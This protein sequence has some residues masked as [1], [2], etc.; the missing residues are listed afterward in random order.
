[1]V[2]C[3]GLDWYGKSRPHWDSIPGQS[4]RSA[5]PA[6]L[7]DARKFLAVATLKLPRQ[8]NFRVGLKHTQQTDIHA[9]GGIR[10][11]NLSRRAVEDLHLRRRGYWDR[12]VFLSEINKAS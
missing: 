8:H 3:D 9:P 6:K 11:H 12:C 2:P 1:M 10:T 7:S 5:S 4:T